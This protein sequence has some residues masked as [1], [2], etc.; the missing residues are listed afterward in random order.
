MP[1]LLSIDDVRFYLYLS[2]SKVDVLYGQMYAPSARKRRTLSAKTPIV[3]ASIESE[4]EESVGGD[5]KL[6]LVE[7]ELEA[8]Q[9]IGTVEEPK[10]YFRAT[11]PMRWGTFHDNG[12]RPDDEPA[13]V[14]FGGFDKTVPL[15]VGLGGSSK[16]VIGWEGA[17]STWSRSATPTIVHW[18]MAGLQQDAPPKSLLSWEEEIEEGEL[19]AAMAIALHHLKPPTQD[20]EFL[21][22]TL[23]TGTVRGYES[24]IGVPSARVILGTPLYVAQAH[25]LPDDNRWGLDDQW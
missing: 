14:Y 12:R 25:P 3:S 11:I 10:T 5:R 18:L 9:L 4:S 23:K 8:R 6:R 19:F 16:H 15:V 17:T 21:A 2:K 22:K 20:M 24:F 1:K 7:E 13:L